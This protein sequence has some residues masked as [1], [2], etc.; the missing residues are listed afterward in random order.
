LDAGAGAS[1]V[2]SGYQVA[3]PAWV[4]SRR[5]RSRPRLPTCRPTNPKRECPRRSARATGRPSGDQSERP[6]HH[7]GTGVL[8]RDCQSCLQRCFSALPFLRPA[9]PPCRTHCRD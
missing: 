7:T 9:H 1:A 8:T 5:G 6:D 2:S 3:R 4:R